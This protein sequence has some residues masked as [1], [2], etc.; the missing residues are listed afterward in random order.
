MTQKKIGAYLDSGSLGLFVEQIVE[1][2][3]GA[4][5]VM[6][7]DVDGQLAWVGPDEDD[8]KRCTVN[9]FVRER[10]TGPGFREQLEGQNLAY[11]F[12]LDCEESGELT[13]ALSVL[14]ES[15]RP[16]SF[17]FAYRELQPILTCI[18]RQ[19]EINAELSSVRRMSSAGRMDWNYS[20]RWTNLTLVPVLNQFCSQCLSFRQ[21]TS[22]VSTR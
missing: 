15:S 19:V 9:P 22:A 12:Y 8:R 13:G 17:E 16:V 21:R 14:V 10:A 4:F 11:V 3:E 6:I 7:H 5:A 1:A 2:L 20:S 18:E